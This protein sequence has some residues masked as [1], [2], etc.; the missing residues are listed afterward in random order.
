MS[1]VSV[2]RLHLRSWRFFPGFAVYSFASSRQISRAGGFVSGL[3]AGDAERGYWTVTVWRDEASMRAFRNSGAHLR[4]MGRLLD[5][6][7]ETS[8]AHWSQESD[9][10]PSMPTAFERLRA[11]GRISKVRHP[12]ARQAAGILVGSAP[13]KPGMALRPRS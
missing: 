7:D 2:T 9:D 3:V 4:A 13:P 8:V 12:S 1:F 11:G 5:W 6:C 10:L